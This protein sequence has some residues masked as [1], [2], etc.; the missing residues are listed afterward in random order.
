MIK[1]SFANQN[2]NNATLIRFIQTKQTTTYE[3]P[4]CPFKDEA[5][6]YE[7]GLLQLK[8]ITQLLIAQ[9]PREIKAL[10]YERGNSLGSWHVLV[11]SIN[12]G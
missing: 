9:L 10:L 5:L 6:L 4:I 2:R 8:P 3:E 12:R 11:C 1:D 7:E